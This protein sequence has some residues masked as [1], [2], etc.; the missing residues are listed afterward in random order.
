MDLFLTAGVTMLVLG[1]TFGALA[2]RWV[3]VL[4]P[5]VLLLLA[6]FGLYPDS[7][8]VNSSS[9]GGAAVFIWLLIA[10]AGASL[11]VGTAVG[12]LARRFASRFARP[13]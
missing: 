7:D 1:A 2:N 6:G 10:G 13:S 8:E 9:T 3:A 11:T 5:L 4:L 12:V